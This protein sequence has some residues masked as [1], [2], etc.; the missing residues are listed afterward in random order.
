MNL[1]VQGAV[2]APAALAEVAALAGATQSL[3]LGASAWRFAGAT[4]DARAE[5][6]CADHQVDFA[7]VP[8]ERRLADLRLVAMDMDS[9]LVTIESIDEMGDLLGIREQIAAVTAQAMRGEIDYPEALRRRVALLAGLEEQ[10]LEQICEE[11]MHLSPGAETLLL[12]CRAAGIRTL[13]VSGGF[14]FFTA[15]LQAR[16][17]IDSVLSNELEIE[18][19]RLTGRVVGGI[20]DG[21]AKAARLRSEIDQLGITREQAV[22]VGDGANDIPMMAVAGVSIAYRAKPLVREHATHALDYAGLDGVLNL[23]VQV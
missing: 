15:W 17:G 12:R 14:S 6:W 22:A 18:H 5:Q 21:A 7:W 1:V 20:V 19:G 2:L 16:L 13:L 8:D 10:S 4:R 23:F 9:T 11:R 3:A